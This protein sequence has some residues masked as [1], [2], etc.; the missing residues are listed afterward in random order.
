MKE[1][2]INEDD[3]VDII[4]VEKDSAFSDSDISQ[5]ELRYLPAHPSAD[6]REK[7][8]E[9]DN[10]GSPLSH[11]SNEEEIEKPPESNKSGSPRSHDSSETES[12]KLPEINKYGY[13]HSH[14]SSEDEIEK[15]PES[16][17]SGSPIL[18]HSSENEVEKLPIGNN[19]GSLVVHDWS[20]NEM[21]MPLRSFKFRSP[22]VN[23]SSEIEGQCMVHIYSSASC[24]ISSL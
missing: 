7:L 9:S 3:E 22:H 5:E 8:P 13:P 16:S 4:T 15:L 24:S 21:V 19:S 20:E 14:N 17:N 23:I 10:A 12:E 11:N 1:S 2:S 18:Q 6:V